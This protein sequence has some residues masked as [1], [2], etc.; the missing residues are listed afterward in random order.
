MTDVTQVGHGDGTRGQ[1]PLSRFPLGHKE[2]DMN[3][4]KAEVW[5]GELKEEICDFEHP[6]VCCSRAIDSTCYSSSIRHIPF[7]TVGFSQYPGPDRQDY[8]G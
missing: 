3:G 4:I 2:R 7:Q 1:G 5:E 6:D 8:S